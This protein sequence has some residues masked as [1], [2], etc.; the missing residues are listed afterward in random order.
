VST[1]NPTEK[2]TAYAVNTKRRRDLEEIAWAYDELFHH[3]LPAAI[4]CYLTAGTPPGSMMSRAT[5][6]TAD[7]LAD[8]LVD[9]LEQWDQRDEHD[10]SFHVALYL[11]IFH[12]MAHLKKLDEVIQASAPTHEGTTPGADKLT[13]AKRP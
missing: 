13:Y 9:L 1:D 8:L 6:A 4:S 2:P 3:E 5:T 11:D 7:V 12:A 10:Q